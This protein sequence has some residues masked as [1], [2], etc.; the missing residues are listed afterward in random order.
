MTAGVNST[1][2]VAP[3]A[4]AAFVPDD[5]LEVAARLE[6]ALTHAHPLAG[7]TAAAVATLCRR[8]IRGDSWDE[9]LMQAA[10]GKTLE[11]VL[12]LQ[13][14]LTTCEDLSEGGFAPQTLRAAVWY[15]HR[16]S[17][18][19]EALSASRAF[20]GPDNHCPVLVGAIGGARWGAD[21]IPQEEV[22]GNPLGRELREVAESFSS[23][24]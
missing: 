9:A 20:A 12:A 18:L 5:E 4:A 3:L 2:R 6:S 19:A 21:A 8:L 23:G 16:S 22:E 24:W 17:H 10:A 7:E 13:P 15:L 1:H 11:V 14:A